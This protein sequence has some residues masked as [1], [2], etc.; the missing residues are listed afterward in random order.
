MSFLSS[1]FGAA[2]RAVTG[3][4]DPWTLEEVKKD[5]RG[6]I[7]KASGGADPSVIKERQ[8]QADA[9][10]DGYLKSVDAHPSQA[11]VRIPGLG[12]IG[13]PEFL[14]K[15]KVLVFSAL[16]IGAF[17]LVVYFGATFLRVLKKVRG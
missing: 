6:G 15:L 14:A 9:E 16:G 8:R 10:I 11:G 4:V 1:T 12:V 2:F 17:L 13:S 5:T 7:A 3:N